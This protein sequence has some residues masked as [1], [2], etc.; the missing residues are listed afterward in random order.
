MSSDSPELHHSNTQLT[1]CDWLVEGHSSTERLTGSVISHST[2]TDLG[3]EAYR[4]RNMDNPAA[5]FGPEVNCQNGQAPKLGASGMSD[6]SP[7]EVVLTPLPCRGD[8]AVGD[9]EVGKL[10][11]RLNITV[12]RPVFNQPEFDEH[13]EG[14]ARYSQS[15]AECCGELR[16]NCVCSASCW[17]NNLKEFFPFVSIFKAYEPKKELLGDLVSGLTVGVMQIPQGKLA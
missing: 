2:D 14:G 6:L 11:E 4:L 1:A 15:C 8:E 9:E 7:P 13:F 10:R 17:K 5:D 16:T 12:Q 3:T